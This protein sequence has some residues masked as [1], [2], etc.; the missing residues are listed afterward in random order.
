MK[1]YRPRGIYRIL[2]YMSRKGRYPNGVPTVAL[3][4]RFDPDIL[5]E[6]RHYDY[7]EEFDRNGNAMRITVR[8]REALKIHVLTVVNV[9]A[10]V[11]AMLVAV[12][13]LFL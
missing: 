3:D 11:V 9:C 12:L 2:R 6:L 1:K 7:L 5:D 13:A 4:A 8:G 10:A